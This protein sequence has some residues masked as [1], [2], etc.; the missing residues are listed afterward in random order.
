MRAAYYKGVRLWE[1][2]QEMP[3]WATRTGEKDHSGVKQRNKKAN[4][5]SPNYERPCEVR[6]VVETR[7]EDAVSGYR[8]GTAIENTLLDVEDRLR[9]VSTTAGDLCFCEDHERA[10]AISG[11]ET[12]G[13]NVVVN[14]GTPGGG[15]TPAV[16][17]LVLFRNPSTGEGFYEIIEAVGAGTVTC[18]IDSNLTSSWDM[19]RVERVFPQA[20]YERMT[21]AR[22]RD[23]SDPELDCREVTYTFTIYGDPVLP[24]ASLIDHDTT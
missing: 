2:L 15:W 14:H 22:V 11:N 8:T 20:V 16:G 9:D 12:A 3:A 21:K 6:C 10:A 24:A 13:S 19:V 5:Q 7:S 1:C 17:E 4:P 23:E 18:D